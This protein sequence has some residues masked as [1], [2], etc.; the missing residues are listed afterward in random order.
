MEH[1]RLALAQHQAVTPA[2]H[3]RHTWTQQPAQLSANTQICDVQRYKW[4]GTGLNQ[5]NCIFMTAVMIT[6]PD[7]LPVTLGV[8]C[9]VRLSMHVVCH[10][11]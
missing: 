4:Q 2:R 5:H 10:K 1:R 11:V 3:P 6:M 8:Q 7:W 9:T